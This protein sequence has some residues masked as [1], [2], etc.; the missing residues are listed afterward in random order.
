MRAGPL[1]RLIAGFG[2]ITLL[3]IAWM[4]INGDLSPATA[5]IKAAIV[6]GVV[7]V[8]C[9]IT[10]LVVSAAAH[11]LERRAVAVVDS[12]NASSDGAAPKRS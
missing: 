12:A 10:D 8:V 9:R 2:L 6:L 3:P 7:L 11:S 1:R 4:V 5:G